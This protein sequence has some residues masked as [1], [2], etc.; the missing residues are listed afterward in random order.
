M[1]K[2]E[3]DAKEIAEL[4]RLYW[5]MERESRIG[6]YHYMRG[7]IDSAKLRKRNPP[8]GSDADAE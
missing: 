7:L 6:A 5:Q 1:D 2:Q 3:R 4:V 8:E